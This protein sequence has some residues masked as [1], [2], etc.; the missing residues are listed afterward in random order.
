MCLLLHLVA[1]HHLGLLGGRVAGGLSWHRSAGQSSDAPRGGS[2]TAYVA[3]WSAVAMRI[4]GVDVGVAA[5]IVRHTADVIS[6]LA[7]AGFGSA[8]TA[9]ARSL[10]E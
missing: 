1:E 4:V 7:P 10:A 9:A 8:F 6:R 2:I 3:L 5:V